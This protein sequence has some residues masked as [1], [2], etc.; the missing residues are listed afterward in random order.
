LLGRGIGIVFLLPLAYFVVRRYVDRTLGLKLGGIFLL[1][2][3]QGAMGWYMVKSGLINEPHVSQFRL[4]AHLGIALLIYAAMFWVALDLLRSRAEH[5]MAEIPGALRRG[6]MALAALVLF[7]IV[8]GGFVAGIR[9]GLAYNTF[10][11][12]NGYLIPPE[13][14]MLDPWYANF[15]S[16]MA[17]VQFDHRLTAFLLALL[18]VTFW[19]KATRYELPLSARRACHA[20]VAALAVQIGLGIGTVLLVVP[21]WLA[22]LHQAGAV[23]LFAA[24][25]WV[26]HEFGS[27]TSR[28]D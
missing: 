25:L 9:A 5:A 17:T 6:A 27:Q 15:F 22:A 19:W 24:A 14:L 11:L 23:L 10:P 1:G 26:A 28:V 13:I 3:L 16:N 12:M 20:L 8:T 18:V 4:T 7:V 21:V 2:G